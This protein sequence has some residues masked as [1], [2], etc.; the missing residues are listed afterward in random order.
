[1]ISEQ[2]YMF[3]VICREYCD[4]IL[5]IIDSTGK[6]VTVDEVEKQTSFIPWLVEKVINT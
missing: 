1:M 5:P 4:T 6:E 3:S 2:F